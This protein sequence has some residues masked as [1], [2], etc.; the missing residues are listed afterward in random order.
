MDLPVNQ[1]GTYR[2]GAIFLEII[3]VFAHLQPAVLILDAFGTEVAPAA[4]HFRPA[5]SHGTVFQIIAASV[6]LLQPAGEHDTVF[7]EIIGFVFQSKGTGDHNAVVKVIG[8]VIDFRPAQSGDA[9]F[10][11]MV[12]IAVDFLP[13]GQQ[14]AVFQIVASIFQP[15]PAH[16][17]GAVA[18]EIMKFSILFQPAGV[19]NAIV[20]EIIGDAVDLLP[21]QCGNAAFLEVIA[22]LTQIQ[23]AGNRISV[24]VLVESDTVLFAPSAAV[25][26]AVIPDPA[27]YAGTHNDEKNQNGWQ[28]LPYFCFH[29]CSPVVII[30][31]MLP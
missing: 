18:A 15:Q 21:L 9:I 29:A 25:N 4:F 16:H 23:P 31:F 30:G 5:G 19:H 12:G 6:F 3:A 17:H 7:L 22:V 2:K 24:K 10:T 1:G 20:T 28:K 13:A 11:E 14:G 26:I 27:T 8:I